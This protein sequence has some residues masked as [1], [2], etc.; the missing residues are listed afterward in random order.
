MI[1]MLPIAFVNSR[2]PAVINKEM[3]FMDV[4]GVLVLVA[5]LV[6]ESVADYQKHMFRSRPENKGKWVD[7]GLYNYSRHPNYFVDICVWRGVFLI[8]VGALQGWQWSAAVSPLYNTAILLFSGTPRLERIHAQ[9]Y[10][11]SSGYQR[12]K[13]ATPLLVPCPHWLYQAWGRQ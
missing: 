5:G 3:G 11:S 13:S 6:C 8:S 2:S 4:A 10:G 12:Y 9:H 1:F 7:I